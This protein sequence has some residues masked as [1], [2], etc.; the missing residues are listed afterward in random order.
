MIVFGDDF[1]Y[2]DAKKN[3]EAMDAMISFIN[4]NYSKYFKLQYSTPSQYIDAIRKENL[5]Y[6]VKYDDLFPYSDGKD[7]YWT[8][9]FTS[10]PNLKGFIRRASSNF[11]ASEFLYSLKMIDQNI[12][13]DEVMEMISAKDAL[14]DE[15]GVTQHHDGIT[16][17][18]R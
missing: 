6:P 1:T 2:M 9:F 3:Y 5:E 10:R 7:S 18:S 17:T 14:M 11:H 8:G 4:E 15:L 16:G 13:D 12:K